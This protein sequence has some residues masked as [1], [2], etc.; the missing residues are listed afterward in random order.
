[1]GTTFS[2]EKNIEKLLDNAG[3]KINQVLEIFRILFC[4]SNY[5]AY[6]VL[7]MCN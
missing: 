4:N 1:M 3:E 2:R 5:G 7:Y 6:Y